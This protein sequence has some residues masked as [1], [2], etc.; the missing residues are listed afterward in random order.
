MKPFPLSFVFCSLALAVSSRAG[1]TELFNGKNFAAWQTPGKPWSAV[2]SVALDA[3][4]PKAFQTGSGTG[5]SLNSADGKGADLV[6]KESFG[7]CRMHVEFCVPK[8]S[9]SGI[10]L[11]GRY[12]LQVLDSFGKDAVSVHD[13]GAIY[14]RWED[15]KGY[16][17]TAPSVNA[18]K[19]PGEWQ[20]FD[21]TFR[22][23]RFDA[24]GIKIAPA[25]FVKV[26]HNGTV[27]HENV[28][29]SGPTRG[30]A[31]EEVASGPVRVQGDHG[32]VAYRSLKISPLTA[33]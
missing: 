25:T 30:G 16:E 20:T 32:P 24:A 17:G 4:N 33:D 12:E 27:V 9:N 29:C 19:A 3:S 23:P 6:S 8:G 1:E 11:M 7:D 14:E 28:T 2:S 31:E 18:S 13:C 15:N 26:I 22:A 10:Y 21:I 5:V